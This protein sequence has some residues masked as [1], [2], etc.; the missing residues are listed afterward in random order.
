MIRKLSSK[1]P[2]LFLFLLLIPSENTW[3][4]EKKSSDFAYFAEGKEAAPKTPVKPSRKEKVFVS[5]S[6]VDQVH[7]SD[8]NVMEDESIGAY[9]RG[10]LFS[11]IKKIVGDFKTFLRDPNSL[12]DPE[13]IVDL[14]RLEVIRARSQRIISSQ[15]VNREIIGEAFND[16][17]NEFSAH[18]YP[19]INEQSVQLSPE[20][21]ARRYADW[22]R[23]YTYK[24]FA[25]FYS[26]GN[27][28]PVDKLLCN[29]GLTATEVVVP[30]DNPLRDDVQHQAEQ[31]YGQQLKIQKVTDNAL[32]K[33]GID[34]DVLL[35]DAGA[36]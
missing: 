15:G 36:S 16:V 27:L 13:T 23:W 7:Q 10:P 30:L 28:S 8:G 14:A 9:Q 17:A 12:I 6:G 31:L 19:N 24:I 5:P 22:Q 18:D 1:N 29:K 25:C 21:M 3:C 35:G 34:P 4:A 2:L 32:K 20:E 11:S 33:I 26:G